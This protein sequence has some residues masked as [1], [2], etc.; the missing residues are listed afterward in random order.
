MRLDSLRRCK[1]DQVRG[2]AGDRT[3]SAV[4]PHVDA[5]RSPVVRTSIEPQGRR[6]SRW[7]SGAGIRRR[8]ADHNVAR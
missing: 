5:E 3:L 2:S 4:D 8:T 6:L 1:P 7:T